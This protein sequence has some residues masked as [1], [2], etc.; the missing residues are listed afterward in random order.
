MHRDLS[1]YLVLQ[2][3]LRSGNWKP[4]KIGMSDKDANKIAAM[5]A[6]VRGGQE[7]GGGWGC[8]CVR[9]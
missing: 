1:M 2:R 8:T 6:Q 5:F 7:R 9:E 3:A 4:E